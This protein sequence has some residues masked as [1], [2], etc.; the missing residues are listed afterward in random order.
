MRTRSIAQLAAALALPAYLCCGTALAE[1]P[2][3]A[4]QDEAVDALIAAAV[5]DNLDAVLLV[6]GESAREL[7]SGDPIADS[8][9]RAD[10]AVAALEAAKI[11]DWG[12]ER[13]MLS[14][15]NNDWPF[16]IPLVKDEQGWY[17]DVEAGR[18]ELLNRRVGRNELTVMD[19]MRELVAAQHEYAADDRNGDG[20][21]N[22]AKRLLSS[23]GA[24]D[25]LYWPLVEGERE[26][27]VGALIANARVE[28][29]TPGENEGP[30]PFHGYLY[31][32]LEA[33][34]DAAPGG[35]TSYLDDQGRLMK[36]FAFLAYPAE[37]GA[38][39][40]MTFMINERG[41][42]FEKDLGAETA[43]LA[44][45]I[46]AFDPDESWAPVTE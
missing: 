18:E 26:S 29:Y 35:A 17:W 44:K 7:R 10:F 6:L 40:V 27:P 31:R 15:G 19:V 34:G 9:D 22:Y 36:G 4:T 3:Y 21:R 37:Y 23:P 12:P 38:S 28:G 39:G 41:L 13:A 42:L 25:G 8:N 45:A 46:D 16:P 24:R 5:D 14:V 33:Q 2:R 30:Q 43:E 32:L 11:E 1:Q 20:V